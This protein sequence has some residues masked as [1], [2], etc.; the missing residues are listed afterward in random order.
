MIFL[1]LLLLFIFPDNGNL[2]LLFVVV[3]PLISFIIETYSKASS[4]ARL[5]SQNGISPKWLLLRKSYLI[6]FLQ[7]PP[8]LLADRAAYVR[9]NDGC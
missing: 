7:G 2:F 9:A 4:L 6:F 3:V 8:T 1:S 5:G